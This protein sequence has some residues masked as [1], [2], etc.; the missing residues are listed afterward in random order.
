MIKLNLKSELQYRWQL[1]YKISNLKHN[2]LDCTAAGPIYLLNNN[3]YNNKALI[4]Q[5]LEY[6]TNNFASWSDPFKRVALNLSG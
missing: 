6:L 2:P 1:I 3:N 4:P 5:T